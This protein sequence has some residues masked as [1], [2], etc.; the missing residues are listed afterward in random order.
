MNR[1]YERG[2]ISERE[3][4]RGTNVIHSYSYCVHVFVAGYRLPAIKRTLTS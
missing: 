3:S 4:S 2:G 1:D